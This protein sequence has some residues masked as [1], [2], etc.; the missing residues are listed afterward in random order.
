M[1]GR[2]AAPR[3]MVQEALAALEARGFDFRTVDGDSDGW[4]DGLT[5]IHAGGGEEYGGNNP[6][7]I[8]SHQWSL[9]SIVSYDGVRIQEY[10]T[11][12]A[13]RGYDGFPQTQ[14]I[15]RIGVICHENGHFLG[16]PDL[17]DYDY[18]SQGVGRFCLMAGGSWGGDDGTSPVHM[19][20]WCKAYLHWV[21]PTLLSPGGMYSVPA[22]E[23]NPTLYKFRWS[24]SSNEYIL[25]EN[26]QGWG[27]DTDLPGT[28]R[29]IL[30]WHVDETRLWNGNNDD[31]D[32][33]LVDLEEASGIQHLELDQNSGN[34]QD[35]YREGNATSFA[36]TTSPNNLSYTGVPLGLDI[37]GISASGMLMSFNT[38][39]TVSPPTVP[40][41]PTGERRN[42]TVSFVAGGATS[43]VFLN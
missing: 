36:R 6:D 16:L 9:Q 19:S 13:R 23:M 31:Q 25:I 21:T 26:R 2:D 34:D 18:D 20:A 38:G 40:E 42:Q 7:Y 32:H 30:I 28:I 8:W 10:H 5:I 1:T 11:E 17:Y 3:E 33:Y 15:T 22:V 24:S 14:G 35:Y 27:F 29:G 39:E 4:V 37:I 12:P 43:V 41:G